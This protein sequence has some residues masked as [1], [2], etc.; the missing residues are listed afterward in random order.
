MIDFILNPPANIGI[1]GGG[2]LGKMLSIRAKTLGYSVTILDPNPSAPAM[3]VA[4][5]RIIAEFSDMESIKKLAN[6]CEVITYEFE[7][8]DADI[9]IDLE[10]NG[11]IVIPSGK[12]LK[13]IQDK[14]EQKSFLQSINV[15]VP[16]FYKV[17]NKEDLIHC[18]KKLGFPFILKSSKGGYDGKGNCVIKSPADLDWV[19][20]QLN[21][22]NLLAEKYI[23]YSKE[24]SIL[25]S[26]GKNK[27]CNHYPVVENI[28]ED[29][30]L[31]LTK[32]PAKIS[33][34]IANKI[35]EISMKIVEALDDIGLFCIEFF[36]TENG[37]VYINEIAPR[38]HNS[39]HYTIEACETS[40]FE[41][42]LRIITGL[43]LGSTDLIYPAAMVN[44]LGNEYVNGDYQYTGLSQILKDDKIY[45]HLYGKKNTHHL[46]KLGHITVCDSSLSL[47]VEKS[48]NALKNLE[49]K[50]ND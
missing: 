15:E 11:H 33:L 42:L 21:S 36:L 10:N 7:H 37:D 32:A 14:Y 12:T 3:S 8:I 23:N 18:S 35:H 22:T 2:Q 29:S 27:E 43:P 26:I 49:I 39:G 24:L 47:A 45:V 9:L 41:Q 38:P 46:K 13:L 4:D 5:H 34:S 44:V 6:L 28:H 48:L 17:T 25:I 1:I 31:R 50:S 30:I 40:Q 20:E 19:F 16:E